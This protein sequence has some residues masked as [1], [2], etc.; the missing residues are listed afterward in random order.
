MADRC[1]GACCK[2][3]TLKY[4]PEEFE[5][6][7]NDL[8]DGLQIAG[9]IVYLGKYAET[10]MIDNDPSDQ[11]HY[12]CRNFD[13]KDCTIYDTRPRMC[14]TYPNG[15]PCRYRDCQWEQVRL[16]ADFCR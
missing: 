5:A 14:R 7:K 12:T 4:S 3:F 10:D 9:M 2:D 6:K 1:T 15:D 11:H 8:Q 16:K 13:G